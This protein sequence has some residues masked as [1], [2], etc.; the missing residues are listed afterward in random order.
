VDDIVTTM[1]KNAMGRR[2]FTIEA[3]FAQFTSGSLTDSAC[4]SAGWKR[5]LV[6]VTPPGGA[7]RAA[8]DLRARGELAVALRATTS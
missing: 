2:I 4:I 7:A 6:G 8:V 3:L 1:P 5:P